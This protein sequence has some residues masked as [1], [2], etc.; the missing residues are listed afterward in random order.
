MF[1]LRDTE[2]FT[3]KPNSPVPK[4]R[5][6]VEK[7]VGSNIPRF[8]LSMVLQPKMKTRI[9]IGFLPT[10]YDLHSSLLIIRNNLTVIEPVVLYGQGARIDVKVENK[11][12]RAEPSLFDIQP[13]HLKDCFNPKRKF[14]N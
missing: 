10:D 8:T 3:L 1:S 6:E 9:R 4:L 7:V 13:I 5:E 11:T 14:I 2:L 12:T